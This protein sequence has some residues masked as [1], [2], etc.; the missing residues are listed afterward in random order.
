MSYVSKINLTRYAALSHKDDPMKPTGWPLVIKAT[1]VNMPEDIFVFHTMT[2]T[3]PY[4]G[5][6]FE[7]VASVNQLF[8]L[9]K[10]MAISATDTPNQNLP[11]YRTN[12]IELFLRSPAEVEEVWK[13]IQDDVERLVWD[14]NSVYAMQAVETVEVAETAQVISSTLQEM[15]SESN[16]ETSRL[17]M[18][19]R[20]AGDA[21][22]DGA[23]K[24]IV[25]N[26]S[27]AY[28]GWLPVSMVPASYTDPVPA[29]A[30]FFYNKTKHS[31]FNALMP[32]S[33]PYDKHFLYYN[34]LLL[35]YGIV[36]EVT[37][38]TIYW[39]DVGLELTEALLMMLFL[40]N[41]SNQT[42]FAPWP[43][44]YVDENS[45]GTLLPHIYLITN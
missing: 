36:Y 1:G 6:L 40:N 43:P 23:D 13:S 18:F 7:C 30:V 28:E 26:P 39:K 31:E 42:G 10:N 32:L 37:Q 22:F 45:P 17:A 4:Y 20:P 25:V 12:Q 3:D 34:G 8:E 14:Y 19:F 11:Y 35:P 2:S 24:P 9:P 15:P 44:D 41:P 21:G 27:E 16:T 33:T 38:D 5:D 29:D